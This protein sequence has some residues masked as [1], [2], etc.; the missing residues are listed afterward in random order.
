M[1]CPRCRRAVPA[2]SVFCLYC[3]LRLAAPERLRPTDGEGRPPAPVPAAAGGRRPYA[4]AFQALQNDRVRYRLAR[5]ICE[6]APAHTLSEVQE[7]LQRGEFATVLALTPEEADATR[8]RIEALGVHPSLLRLAPASE[9]DFFLRARSPAEASS[10][11]TL[12]QKLLAVG[13]VLVAFFAFGLA[14]LRLYGR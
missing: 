5:W 9:A 8:Q 14:M 13:G 1:D 2:E 12:P 7:A 3:G 10:G 6:V 4:I 11:W